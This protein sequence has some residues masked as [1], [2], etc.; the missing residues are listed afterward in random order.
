[1]I[2]SSAL[3]MVTSAQDGQEVVLMDEPDI[4]WTMGKLT[5]DEA[6]VAAELGEDVNGDPLDAVLEAEG[7]LPVIV[8]GIVPTASD[9]AMMFDAA[10]GQALAVADSPFTNNVPGNPGVTNRTYELWFQPRNLPTTGEEN[11]QIIYMEGG[12]TRGLTIYL[13]GTQGLR[14]H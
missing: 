1:M 2:A 11:R 3:T 13:D 8:N 4:Y 5:D 9:G 12:T 10:E 14:P 6:A 7:D